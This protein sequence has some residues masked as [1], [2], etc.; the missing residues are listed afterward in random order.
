MRWTVLTSKGGAFYIVEKTLTA[1]ATGKEVPVRAQLGGL[2]SGNGS[3]RV[4]ITV[5]REWAPLG[6]ARFLTLVQSDFY[7]EARIFRVLTKRS[8]GNDFVVQFGLAA[9][10]ETTRQWAGRKIVDDPVRKASTCS[11]K[12]CANARGTVVFATSGPGTRTTQ[13]F[14]N[15][16]DNEFLD[17]QGFAPFGSISDSDMERLRGIYDGYGGHPK[18]GSIRS[19]GN[20]YLKREFP[21]LSY[22]ASMAVEPAATA[23]P[24]PTTAREA[25]AHKA[26]AK[27]KPRFTCP[28]AGQRPP[29]WSY[30]VK[31]EWA[32]DP[33]SFTQ[34]LLFEPR[35]GAPQLSTEQRALY[36]GT[37][38]YGRS[39]VA[40]LALH[41]GASAV[42]RERATEARIFGEGV[43]IVDGPSTRVLVF[44]ASARSFFFFQN[45]VGSSRRLA[46]RPPEGFKSS[47]EATAG[48]KG[49]G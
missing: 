23:A 31:Q 25:T 45:A 11:G 36:E 37:G 18:L 19:Q 42:R 12:P 29:V 48:R 39:R 44:F 16:K 24:T 41:K 21:K 28:A 6:A 20:A 8:S 38:L 40:E 26:A 3:A 35:V 49:G 14:I 33:R 34:G 2:T 13:V 5:R 4:T 7:T 22:F 10:P 46:S 15:L 17:G 47:P 9:L 1:A 30:S 27:K 32:H 43:T